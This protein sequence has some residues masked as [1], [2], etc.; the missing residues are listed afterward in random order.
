MRTAAAGVWD[1]RYRI[2]AVRTGSVRLDGLQVTDAAG[3]L[4]ALAPTKTL[5][6]TT[7]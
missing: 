4:H 6:V 5:Y 7:P 2:T 3:T 1:L